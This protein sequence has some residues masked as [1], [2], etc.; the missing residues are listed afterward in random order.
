MIPGKENSLKREAY[1]REHL[2]EVV[3][4]FVKIYYVVLKLGA[5]AASI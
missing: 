3:C 1:I 4:I 5:V 2:R